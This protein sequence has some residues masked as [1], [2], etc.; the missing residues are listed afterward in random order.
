MAPTSDSGSPSNPV[1]ETVWPTLGGRLR[2]DYP[3]RSMQ[4]RPTSVF[5]LTRHLV[6][7][8]WAAL[9]PRGKTIS[10]VAA[11]VLGAAALVGARSAAC[12]AGGCP[13]QEAAAPSASDDCPYSRR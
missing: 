13:Y 3:S 2:W 6:R 8:R 12:C 1:R 9:S 5:G 7:T 10:V 4:Q 11:V